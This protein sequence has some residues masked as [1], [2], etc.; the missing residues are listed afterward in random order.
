MNIGA[1]LKEKQLSANDYHELIEAL[2]VL[3]RDIV[4]TYGPSELELAERAS[5]STPAK[6]APKTDLLEL[7]A[8]FH[9]ADSVITCDTGP[10]HL[11]V[12]VG[13]PT[14][15]IFV[16]TSPQRYGYQTQTHTSFDARNGLPEEIKVALPQWI[17]SVQAKL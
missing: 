14:C 17:A 7:A 2:T 5:K 1:R 8:L 6:L 13:T 4:L 11:A 3:E 15:G 16:S 10:M 9:R 12:A